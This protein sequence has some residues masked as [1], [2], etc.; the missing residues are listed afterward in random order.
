M[1]DKED[2]K[3]G[4]VP[5]PFLRFIIGVVLVGVIVLIARNEYLKNNPPDLKINPPKD[6][7]SSEW[8]SYDE[9]WGGWFDG[10]PY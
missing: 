10:L 4:S 6:R 3:D 1:T 7:S 9:D 2:N 8:H 5:K